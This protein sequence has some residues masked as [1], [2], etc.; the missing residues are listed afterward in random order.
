MG[1]KLTPKVS[2]KD[3]KLDVKLADSTTGTVEPSSLFV[4][5]R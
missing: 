5:L 3:S 2:L 1:L 4:P